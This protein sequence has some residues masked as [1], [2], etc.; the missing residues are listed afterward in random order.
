MIDFQSLSILLTGIGITGAIIYYALT[1]RNANRTRQA[2]LFMQIYEGYASEEIQK[3]FFDL[4]HFE[5]EDYADFEKKY[6]SGDNPDLAARREALWC[7]FDGMGVL[8]RDRLIDPYMVFDT[9]G[10]GGVIIMWTKFESI[11]K[12]QRDYYNLPHRFNGFEY[13]ADKMKQIGYQRG[14][15]TVVSESFDR[16]VE[17]ENN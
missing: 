1:I 8:L 6:G 10:H 11:I 13:L 14:L 12:S 17:T 9:L 3:T 4:L 5:W 15:V 2:Q 16:Y 7:W